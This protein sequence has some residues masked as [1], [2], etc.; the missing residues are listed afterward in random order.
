MVVI[1]P[2]AANVL[3]T[4]GAVCPADPSSI[5]LT[6][7]DMLGRSGRGTARSTASSY[8]GQLIPQIIINHRRHHTQG[9]Q[10]QMMLLWASAGVPLGAYNIVENFNIAL[11][12]QP[13]ILTCLS[14][15]TWMQCC[16]YGKVGWPPDLRA[17]S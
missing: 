1:V 10:P 16:Y 15:L 12:I 14:L 5:D 17:Q 3:G 8:V 13:Q 6:L 4:L 7:A 11:R 9:L 2:V